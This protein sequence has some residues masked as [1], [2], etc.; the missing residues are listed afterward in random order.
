[1]S[2]HRVAGFSHQQ[3]CERHNEVH[4]VREKRCVYIKEPEVNTGSWRIKR[5]NVVTKTRVSMGILKGDKRLGEGEPGSSVT[6]APPE[7][8]LD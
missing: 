7:Q 3:A 2:P 1:M 6:K 5:R 4:L 8:A